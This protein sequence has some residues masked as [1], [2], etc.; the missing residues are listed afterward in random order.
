MQCFALAFRDIFQQLAQYNIGIKKIT[1]V[2]DSLL[3]SLLYQF[4]ICLPVIIVASIFAQEII[5]VLVPI[6]E[7]DR[8]AYYQYMLE[9]VANSATAGAW[10][11][12]LSLSYYIVIQMLQLESKLMLSAV[13]QL[14]ML[15]FGCGYMYFVF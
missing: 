6:P 1:R 2:Y 13:L 15:A 4:S 10:C 3:W 14:P 8:D 11:N 5:P 9:E 7:A 12:F